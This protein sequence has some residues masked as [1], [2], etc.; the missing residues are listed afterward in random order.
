MQLCWTGVGTVAGSVAREAALPYR[1]RSQN[2]D[3]YI[4]QR[5]RKS[6]THQLLRSHYGTSQVCLS[7]HL[8]LISRHFNRLVLA[9]VCWISDC[10]V[11]FFGVH[12]YVRL[13]AISQPELDQDLYSLA[14]QAS[15]MLDKMH[16]GGKIIEGVSAFPR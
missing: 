14:T 6:R 12:R 10:S 15:T 5:R 8:E 7:L 13:L 3:G 16:P 11:D 2:V 1:S 9:R 4:P